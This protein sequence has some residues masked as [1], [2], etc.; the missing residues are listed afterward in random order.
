MKSWS[1]RSTASAACAAAALIL[2]SV[3]AAAQPGDSGSSAPSFIPPGFPC[4]PASVT[5]LLPWGWGPLDGGAPRYAKGT[6]TSGAGWLDLYAPPGGRTNYFHP[7]INTALRDLAGSADSL[8][9]RH[10]GQYTSFQ[11]RLRGANRTDDPTGFTTLVWWPPANGRVGE[12]GWATTALTDGQWWSTKPIEGLA[13]EQDATATLSEIAE[14]NPHAFVTEY[15]VSNDS[16]NGAADDVV[17][18]CARWDFEPV[19]SGS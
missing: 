10:Q 9:F 11:L 8:S 1:L 15:G 16:G 3:P 17:Y 7:G 14:A 5:P 12:N 18:G 6:D 13:G 19:P 4:I 2:F